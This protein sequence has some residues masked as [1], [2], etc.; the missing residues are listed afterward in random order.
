MNE[1]NK[2]PHQADPD[3]K[4]WPPVWKI[5]ANPILRRY[6][7]SRLRIRGLSVWLL[8]TLS[9]FDLAQGRI[10]SFSAYRFLYERLLGAQVRPWLPAAFCAAGPASVFM[11]SRLRISRSIP[12]DSAISPA[13]VT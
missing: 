2:P 13:R 4:E 1:E 12:F 10:D 6:C 9:A 7:R 5:W 3:P 8:T 11:K